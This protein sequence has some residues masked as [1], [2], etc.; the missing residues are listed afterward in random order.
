MDKVR[1]KEIAEELGIKSKEVVEKA[2]D[3]GLV[4][5]AANSSV[6][7]E[8]AEKLMNYVLT[9]VKEESQPVKPK[10]T[11]KKAKTKPKKEEPK[12][13]EVV[14]PKKKKIPIEK[15]VV[16]KSPTAKVEILKEESIQEPKVEKAEVKVESKEHVVKAVVESKEKKSESK[17]P[18]VKAKEPKVEPKKES[19]ATASVRKRRGL[20]IVKKKRPLKVEADPKSFPSPYAKKKNSQPLE[21]VFG[22]ASESSKKKKKVKKKI[23]KIK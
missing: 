21:S 22:V 17:K 23:Y 15:S 7:H 5:K 2:T 9:G 18:V 19:L 8:E 11:V 20:V 4:V 1:I 16:K 3:I 10:P 12:P 14:T 13:Q 6:T